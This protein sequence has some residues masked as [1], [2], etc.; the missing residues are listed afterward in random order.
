M[1]S[2][3]IDL[4]GTLIKIALI[5]SGVIL[6][7]RS[8]EA[9]SQKG[10]RANLPKLE[11]VINDLLAHQK[12]KNEELL[13]IGMAFPGLVNPITKKVISTNEKYDDA[14]DIDLSDWVATNW[15]V[16]FYL[17]NDARMAVV[18]EWQKGAAINYNDVVMMTIGTGIGTGV[19]MGGKILY[20][21]HF[22]AGSLGGHFVIDYKGEQCSCGNIGCVEAL[23]SS[24]FLMRTIRNNTQIS[25]S[26]K[27]GNKEYDFK[28]IFSLAKE[29]NADA[30]VICNQCMDIWAGAI[31][32]YIHAYDPDVVVIGGGVMKSYDFIIPYLKSKIERYA[33]CPSG[34]VEIKVAEL[35]DNAATVGIEYQLLNLKENNGKVIL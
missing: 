27:K 22:Q 10:L 5:E 20:G 4:G 19:I 3:C 33:W 6:Q 32:T 8:I 11:M 9:D 35:G 31:I 13:G 26:F 29:G 12:I 17:D 16:S 1:Y 30:L 15:G 21:K 7:F 18:G 28:E 2:I 14:N 24:Y 25:D 34:K 23:S